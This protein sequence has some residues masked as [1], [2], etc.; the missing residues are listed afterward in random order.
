MELTI[1][2]P[3][4]TALSKNKSHR[5]ISVNKRV[6]TRAYLDILNLIKAKIMAKLDG[7]VFE[8][9]KVFCYVYIAK[10]TMRADPCN[11]L[12]GILD[13]V[14]QGIGVDDRWFS[15]SWDWNIDTINPRIEI[16]IFQKDL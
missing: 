11:L 5:N 10:D 9:R 13:G 3:F 1:T 7:K 12:D 2:I 8:K 16:T 6:P 15:G 4:D 14:K